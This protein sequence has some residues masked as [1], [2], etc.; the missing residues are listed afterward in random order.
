MQPNLISPVTC[1]ELHGQGEREFSATP[2][3]QAD[4]SAHNIHSGGI[5]V[6]D[7]GEWSLTHK[8]ARRAFSPTSAITY[9]APLENE[10]PVR[11]RLIWRSAWAR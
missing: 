3:D 10:A 11:A 7:D 2:A 4:A 8:A 6:T 1:Q 5:R 9:S